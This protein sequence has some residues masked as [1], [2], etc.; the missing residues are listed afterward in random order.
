MRP[1]V[2]P[3]EK[4]RWS[5]FIALPE[6]DRRELIDGRLEEIDMPTKWHEHICM[7][8][9]VALGVW[10]QRRKGWLVLGS[11]YKVRVSDR[12]GIMPD[13]QVL[14]EETYLRAGALGLDNGRPELAIEVV[15]P[16]SRAHD[17]L[18]K[19][20]WYAK[21]GVPEYWLVDPETRSLVVHQLTG[22]TYLIAQHCE[23]NA[24]FR[25]KTFKGLR[26][27]LERLWLGVPR[28]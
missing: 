24:V 23:G 21:L 16:T 8:L 3:I 26:I 11:G 28:D 22:S 1:S 7:V 18:R 17:R 5:D 12:R 13:V 6:D 20:D 15:S 27:P 2:A 9:G 4:Y 19:L 14:K 25:S 10:A